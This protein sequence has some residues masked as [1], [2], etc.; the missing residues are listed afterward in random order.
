[1]NSKIDFNSIKELLD[2]KYYKYNSPEF[3]ETDPVS[4]PHSFSNRENIEISAFLS[5]TIAWGH[6]TSIIKNAF[7]LM[8]LMDN[9]PYNFILNSQNKDYQVFEKF[10]HRTFNASDVVF[11]I[12]SLGNI[13][14]NHGGL[15][16]VFTNHYHQ[17]GDIRSCL[18]YFREVFFEWPHEHRTEKHISNISSKA[19]CKRLN[20]FLRWMVRDDELGVD[21]GLWKGISTS[22]LYIPLDIH[23]GNVSR[24]L[25]LLQRKQN[26]W[27]A[28]EELTSNLRKFDPSDP[29]K[30]DFALFGLGIFE[31]FTT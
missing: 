19:A 2:E 21:F 29:V 9:D 30:Y 22:A 31:K 11:F 25:G 16:T 10:C 20:L 5:A 6:R 13:Y 15:E 4:I 14:K 28:V 27:P 26:D 8:K 24:N 1:M 23:I 17:T 18:K 12:K 3:I 7:R